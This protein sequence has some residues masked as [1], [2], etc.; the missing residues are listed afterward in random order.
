MRRALLVLALLL[1]AACAPKRVYG[2]Y[3]GPE[4]DRIEVPIVQIVNNNM[5]DA[6]VS[7]NGRRIATQVPGL[8]GNIL[9]ALRPEEAVGGRPLNFVVHL[10]NTSGPSDKA[11]TPI[12][13]S[14]EKLVIKIN[15]LFSTS[16]VWK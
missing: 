10:T 4:P 6:H 12:S 7:L 8:T 16:D 1:S 2:D 5:S 13:W 9:V 14:G 15:E 3:D 11:L